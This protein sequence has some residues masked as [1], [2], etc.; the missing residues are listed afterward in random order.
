M[1]EAADLAAAVIEAAAQEA[2]EVPAA[3]E[4]AVVANVDVV[5]NAEA[6]AEDDDAVDVP[7]A[8]NPGT[9]PAT[10]TMASRGLW[11]L[12]VVSSNCTPTDMDFSAIRD[13]TTSGCGVIRLYPA[14]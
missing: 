4:E 13:K 12:A 1:V 8:V 6:A 3:E 2:V 14:R 7:P 11:S 9:T 5:A 10:T